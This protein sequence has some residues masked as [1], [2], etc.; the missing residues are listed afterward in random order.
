MNSSR[1]LCS[2]HAFDCFLAVNI[3]TYIYVV[4]RFTTAAKA[5]TGISKTT[6]PTPIGQKVR[7]GNGKAF[8][9]LRCNLMGGYQLCISQ[10]KKNEGKAR[11]PMDDE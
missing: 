1:S 7:P 5:K 9:D 8:N 4:S 2:K 11:K 3:F 6:T 10:A